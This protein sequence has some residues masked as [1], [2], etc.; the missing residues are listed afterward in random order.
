[1]ATPRRQ[2]V[3]PIDP[4]VWGNPPA[5]LGDLLEPPAAADT[6]VAPTTPKPEP[7]PS[8]PVSVTVG[9]TDHGI[10][11]KNEPD[12]DEIINHNFTVNPLLL[13]RMRTARE[14]LAATNT[15]VWAQA[16]QECEPR[17]DQLFE[18]NSWSK[19]PFAV[20]RRKRV[21][22]GAQSHLRLRMTQAQ[23]DFLDEEAQQRGAESTS[24]FV[25]TVLN[26]FFDDEGI[27]PAKKR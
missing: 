10:P 7:K 27:P 21:S 6:A 2:N 12:P 1:M 11:N 18:A 4:S 17:L 14:K 26:T 9:G 25:E 8:Q 3:K 24:G 5:G 20:P 15:E 16:Y 23:R 22:V 13:D 19:S